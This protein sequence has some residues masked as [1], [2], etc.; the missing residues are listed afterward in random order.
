MAQVSDKLLTDQLKLMAEHFPADIAYVDVSTGRQISF[1]EWDRE[2]DRLAGALIEARVVKGD[3]VALYLPPE[4]PLEWLVAYAATHK[5][6]GVAVPINTRLARRELELVL[7]HSGAVAAFAGSSTTAT[8]AAAQAAAPALQWVATTASTLPRGWVAWDPLKPCGPVDVDVN[9]DDI[10]DIMY[11]SGTTGRPK[12]VVVRHRNAATMPYGLPRW[13][14]DGWLH[15]SPLFTFAGIASVY[16]PMKLGMTGLYLPRFEAGAWL[17]A[18]ERLRPAA[19][20]LVPAMA[21]LLLSHDRFLDADLT[22]IRM[23]S[24][25]SA[26]LA[27]ETFRQ[28]RRRLPDAWVSNNWGMTEAGPAFCVLPPDE[29]AHR[30]GSVGKPIPPVTLRIIDERGRDLAPG[31]VGE[32]LVSNPGKEREYFRDPETTAR[33]WRDGWLHTGDLAYLDA[34]GFLYIAGRKKDVIIRGGHNVHAADVE[35]ALLEHPAVVDAAVAGVPHPVLGEDVAAWVVPRPDQVV[36]GREL[37]NFLADRLADYKV[38][39]QITFV[40]EL[41]RNAT[42]KVLKDQLTP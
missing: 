35:S 27:P 11:T 21:Q 14:G 32:L 28:L 42:G 31:D 9:G 13:S 7:D 25:G 36:D 2:S 41:P 26:P 3:R 1:Q 8:L 6:G 22:S 37:R 4:E 40:A 34:D 10:A 19:V 33:T 15:C 38:P 30:V 12:G 29:A 20:F 16:N 39:R 23:A 17:D 24:I 5:A 18:V